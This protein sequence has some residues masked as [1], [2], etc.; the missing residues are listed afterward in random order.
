MCPLR[1]CLYQHLSSALCEPRPAL[2]Q[3]PM[4]ASIGAPTAPSARLDQRL[5]TTLAGGVPKAQSVCASELVQPARLGTGGVCLPLRPCGALSASSTGA[6]TALATVRFDQCLNSAL[7][8][9]RP[10]LLRR[11]LRVF[12]LVVWFGAV[13]SSTWYCT[14]CVLRPALPDSSPC[15]CFC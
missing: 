10:A 14:L 11:R 3:R 2:L 5:S 1:T 8:A 12:S 4:C 6:V 7:C 13:C 9:P 15:I